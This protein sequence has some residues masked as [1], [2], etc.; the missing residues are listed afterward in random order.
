MPNALG[1]A[2]VL[3][4]ASPAIASP[5]DSRGLRYFFGMGVVMRQAPSELDNLDGLDRTT[6]TARSIDGQQD[7]VDREVGPRWRVGLELGQTLYV[8]LDTG[9]GL[10]R[11]PEGA[12][13][14]PFRDASSVTMLGVVGARGHVGRGTLGVE[15][16]G[17]FRHF[18]YCVGESAERHDVYT[19]MQKV[20]EARVRAERAIGRW[21][22]LGGAIGTSLVDDG[23]WVGTLDVTFRT[24]L[25]RRAR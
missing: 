2:L 15:V 7:L 23:A 12:P 11:V 6:Y 3:L 10:T 25:R 17:G 13:M 24:S 8:A 1:L 5:D 4:A 16:G 20:V 22:T 9:F 21:T 14:A 19:G 18:T